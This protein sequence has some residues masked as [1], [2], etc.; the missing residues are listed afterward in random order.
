MHA[1]KRDKQRPYLQ[2][3]QQATSSPIPPSFIV[4]LSIL[5]RVL[6]T[7]VIATIM[8]G[9]LV[10]WSPSMLYAIFSGFVAAD[11]MIDVFPLRNQQLSMVQV[12]HLP[13]L[14]LNQ[15]VQNKFS[16][17]AVPLRKICLLFFAVSAA[18]MVF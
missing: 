18:C 14:D 4:I 16:Y 9:P 10:V 15:E 11:N 7:T 13:L 3:Q 17:R 5:A 6:F 8:I 12:T 2:K 1:K